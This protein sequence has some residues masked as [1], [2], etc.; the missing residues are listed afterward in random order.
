M[1]VKVCGKRHRALHGGWP[2]QHLHVFTDLGAVQ[3]P[4]YWA[5]RRFHPGNSTGV[6]CHFLLQRIFLTQGSNPG[7][8]HCRQM[9]YCLSHQ[10]RPF[11]SLLHHA[12]TL[13]TVPPPSLQNGGGAESSKLP[14]MAQLSGDQPT[15]S[16]LIRTRHSI[17]QESQSIQ[18]PC[19]ETGS[20]VKYQGNGCSWYSH[21]GEWVGGRSNR[22]GIYVYTTADSLCCS[23]ETNTTL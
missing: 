16:C 13:F 12:I 14:V 19:I 6:G 3:I 7:L 11:T 18:K 5:F 8:W 1:Q 21:C 22:E 10:G 20:K 9:L 2:F 17:T 23:A 4:G 15:K